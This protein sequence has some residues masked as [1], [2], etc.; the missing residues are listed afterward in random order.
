MTYEECTIGCSSEHH[1]HRLLSDDDSHA[2]GIDCVGFYGVAFEVYLL[3]C[4]LP[5]RSVSE[6]KRTYPELQIPFHD[7]CCQGHGLW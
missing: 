7:G 1:F 2:Y 6:R 3:Q 4:F 5:V